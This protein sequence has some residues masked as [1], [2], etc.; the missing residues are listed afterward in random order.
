M[1][2]KQKPLRKIV[3]ALNKRKT[4]KVKKNRKLNKKKTLLKFIFVLFEIYFMCINL[5]LANM[6]EVRL[7]TV[8]RVFPKFHFYQFAGYDDPINPLNCSVLLTI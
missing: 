8:R 1:K 4:I 6:H 7:V 5:V 3:V 2:R